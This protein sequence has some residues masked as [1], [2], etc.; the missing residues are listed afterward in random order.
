MKHFELEGKLR[1]DLGKSASRKMRKQ[2][3]VPCVLYGKGSNINFSVTRPDIRNLM[4]SPNVYLVDLTI[5]SKMYPCVIKEIQ[6]DPVASTINH[7]D[8]Y[9]I[10][11]N[12]PVSIHV[13]MN[14]VGQSIG[15][16]IGG[17]LKKNQRMLHVRALPANLPDFIELDITNLDVNQSIK[18]KDVVVE[19]VEMLDPKNKVLVIVNSARGVEAAAAK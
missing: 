18:V 8:F 14:L 3:V 9:A 13:P 19:N 10:S 17:K 2:D 15:V 4:Y 5:E 11:D 12:Q 7:I 16:K 1:T 6:S